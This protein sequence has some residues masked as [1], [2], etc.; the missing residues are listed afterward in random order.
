MEVVG[1][2]G[3]DGCVCAAMPNTLFRFT[4]SLVC[5]RL[6]PHSVR[7]RHRIAGMDAGHE[8]GI[9]VV[10]HEK[11]G[12]S[13][14]P[15][16]TRGATFGQTSHHHTA[17]HDIID[18]AEQEQSSAR[19]KKRWWFWSDADAVAGFLGGTCAG[20]FGASGWPT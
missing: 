10:A 3:S 6:A 15:A 7:C 5:R 16:R 11:W 17:P 9:H 4:P 18:Y 14:K 13:A 19:T 1:V 8:T 12:S 20:A 2:E